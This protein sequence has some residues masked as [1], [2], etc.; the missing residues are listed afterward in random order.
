MIIFLFILFIVFDL[1]LIFVFYHWRKN[2]T[3]LKDYFNP[4]KIH[5]VII[6]FCQLYLKKSGLTNTYLTR[7]DIFNYG[8]RFAKCYD[9]VIAGKCID[10]QCDIAGK[11]N[12]PNETCSMKKFGTFNSKEELD[13]YFSNPANNFKITVKE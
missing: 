11:F 1:Y 6:W 4:K 12:N 5:H 9:C 13:E 3:R 7:E 10:C 2:K 8:Y